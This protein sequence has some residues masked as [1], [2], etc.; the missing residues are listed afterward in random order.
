MTASPGAALEVQC[1]TEVGLATLSADV[2]TKATD[3]AALPLQQ[4]EGL[5]AEG[6]AQV[7]AR[8]Y[9]QAIEVYTK[10]LALHADIHCADTECDEKYAKHV[11]F[12]NRCLCYMRLGRYE[13]AKNDAQ[14][15]VTSHPTYAKGYYRLAQCQMEIA[16]L[17]GAW[18]SVTRASRLQPDDAEIRALERRVEARERGEE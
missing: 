8:K 16:D 7:K 9:S 11:F 1:A 10:A 2:A 6:N 18:E 13:E 17:A 5:K 3:I 12:G 15:A 4:L 14:E